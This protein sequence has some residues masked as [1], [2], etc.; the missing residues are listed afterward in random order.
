MDRNDPRSRVALALDVPGLEAAAPLIAQTREHIGVYKV[1][2][3]LF[4]AAGPFAVD[5]VL[6]T[7]ARCFLDLKMHDIPATMGRAVTQAAG[8]GVHYLTVHASAGQRALE[9]AREAAGSMRLLAVTVLTSFD[10]DSLEAIGFVDGPEPAAKRLAALAWSA[11]IRGFVCSPKEC[12]GLRRALGANAFL[13]TPG[14]R[15]LGNDPGDQRR[16]ATPK[17][18]IGAGSDLLVVGRPIRDADDPR[19]AA[20]LF[21]DEV[22]AAL[23]Q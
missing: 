10:R 6:E 2:L 23:R 7:G 1:G 21:V 9:E 3:E 16:T 4:A 12:G 8:L 15:A 5:M 11:G 13:V 17:A 22:E 18:A 20:G 14:I 19:A